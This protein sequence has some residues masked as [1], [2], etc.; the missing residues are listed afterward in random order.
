MIYKIM[1]RNFEDN[2]WR[3]IESWRKIEYCSVSFN[4]RNSQSTHS[5]SCLSLS[6][7]EKPQ[8]MLSRSA[9]GD[10]EDRSAIQSSVPRK[11]ACTTHSDHRP[12]LL[13][14]ISKRVATIVKLLTRVTPLTQITAAR[15]I[16][17]M[18]RKALEMMECQVYRPARG[19]GRVSDRRRDP[20]SLSLGP[21]LSVLRRGRYL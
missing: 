3:R 6:H 11:P 5:Q 2:P 21:E 18:Q 19:H 20:R 16:G 1:Q 7:R 15:S 12:V 8:L 13:S 17:D 4:L 10:A 9:P 14:L